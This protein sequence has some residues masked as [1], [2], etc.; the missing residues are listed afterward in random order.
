MLIVVGVFLK[1]DVDTAVL[2]TLEDAAAGGR[3]N[4]IRVFR[5]GSNTS[6]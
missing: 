2:V 4:M 5:S 6:V 1:V 3:Y